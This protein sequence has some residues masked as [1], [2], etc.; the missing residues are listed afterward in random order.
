MSHLI[1]VQ[2]EQILLPMNYDNDGTSEDPAVL[3]S[4]YADTTNTDGTAL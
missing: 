2:V 4:G 3:D 1:L